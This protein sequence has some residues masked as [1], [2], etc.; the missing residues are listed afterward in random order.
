MKY[1]VRWKRNNRVSVIFIFLFLDLFQKFL[2]Q[3]RCNTQLLWAWS[4]ER[5]LKREYWW[6]LEMI[7]EWTF[8]VELLMLS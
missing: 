7:Y 6:A 8:S 5:Y 1:F 2:K 3:V 4:L